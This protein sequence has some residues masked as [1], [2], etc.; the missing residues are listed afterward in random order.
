MVVVTYNTDT[1]KNR[2]KNANKKAN[3]LYI[4]LMSE[5]SIKVD[6][7]KSLKNSKFK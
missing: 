6:S 1:R 7:G 3:I 4:T 5:F 2:H